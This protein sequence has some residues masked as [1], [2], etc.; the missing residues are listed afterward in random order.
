M[1]HSS[2]RYWRNLVL[3]LLAGGGM[4]AA[5]R[6]DRP[7]NVLL[8][9]VDDLK[10]ALGCYGDQLARTPHLDRL[11]ARGLRF[12]R[13]YCNQAVCAPSRN[14]LL[15]GSR[16]TSLGI[17]DLGTNFRVAVPDAVTLPQHFHQHG[18][19]TAGIGKVFHIGHGNAGDDASWSV[20]FRS[21]PVV[22]Y[23]LPE[24]SGAGLT[25][26]QALFSN[27]SPQGLPRGAAW[28]RADVNDDAY[29]D[30]R[31]A[32]AGVER[33]EEFSRSGEP[34][35]LALGFVKPHL[36]FCAPARYW[37]LH[38]PAAF[39][40]A[41]RGF[42][43]DGAPAYAGKGLVELNQ[44]TPIPEQ[45]PISEELARTLIHGYYASVSYM[46]AQVGRVLD[47]LD[48]LQLADK[49]I[50]LLWGDH[51]Y[52]LGDHGMWTKHTNYEQACR[53]PLLLC[54]PGVSTPGS[55][56][57]A[58]VESV[59]V[60]PTLCELAGV[61][62]PGGPQPIDGLSL[63]SIL[64]DPTA[65]VREHAYHC[66]PRGPNRLGRALR[67]ERYRLVEWKPFNG[68]AA[69]DFE[70]YDYRDDPLEA[71]NLAHERPDVVAALRRELDRHPA[72]R[73][74][75]RKPN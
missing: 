13:A 64:R 38:D 31:I 42:P 54:A 36:P 72:P 46:D 6:A 71:R 23:L 34:F 68:T 53:I 16:S 24:N 61:P 18:Y 25:R 59:D 20:P 47:A 10:P 11:A 1:P 45:P 41:E 9:L 32:A 73:P 4:P 55:S 5:T 17:Y 56:T 21:E 67:S 29:A 39:P 49:T 22:E 63:T 27:R 50:V 60:F 44:Y 7:P 48:R 3:A 74:P 57:A 35:L 40:L 2:W 15:V 19:Q 51:G 33:L 66:Y 37:D 43:P 58:L 8:I 70:L 30:G 14:S 65:R 28:E 52:H 62:P 69:P 26:E 75:V 12:D